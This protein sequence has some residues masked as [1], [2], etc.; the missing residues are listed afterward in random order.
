VRWGIFSSLI[1]RQLGKRRSAFIVALLVAPEHVAW[2][3]RSLAN[4]TANDAASGISGWVTRVIVLS[5]VD[6]DCS[7]A[8]MKDRVGLILVEGDRGVEHF[9]IERSTC[10]NVKVRHIAGVSRARHYPVVRVGRI[11]MTA[12]RVEAGRLALA[13]RMDMKGMLSR[14][15]AIERK[16]K[17]HSGG[18]LDERDGALLCL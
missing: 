8:R 10:R 4:H 5:G 13:H 7:A 16:L 6:Y 14:R 9:E 2:S 11:E 3:R 1:G 12:C 17:Q 18:G 15:H